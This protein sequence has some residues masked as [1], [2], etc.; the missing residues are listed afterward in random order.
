VER[1][2]ESERRL[3]R[4]FLFG[5]KGTRNEYSAVDSNLLNILELILENFY[6]L[7]QYLFAI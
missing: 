5:K 3:T 4:F 6:E 7:H 2:F 1:Q